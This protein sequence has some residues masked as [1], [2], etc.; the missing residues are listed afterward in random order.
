M[1][2]QTAWRAW[3]IAGAAEDQQRR[4][5]CYRWWK[6]SSQNRSA[7]ATF[8]NTSTNETEKDKDRKIFF[9]FLNK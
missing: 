9:C 7:V 2:P 6:W 5:R 3:K 1:E 8:V 4:E